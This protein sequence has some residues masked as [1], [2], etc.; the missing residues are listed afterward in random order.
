VKPYRSR[1]AASGGLSNV[2]IPSSAPSATEANNNSDSSH[3]RLA[4]KVTK[5]IV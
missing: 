1:S 4:R 5:F 2:H 3:S